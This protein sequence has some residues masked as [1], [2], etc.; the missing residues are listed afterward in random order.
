LTALPPDDPFG[1]RAHLEEQRKKRRQQ[2]RDS[3]LGGA[4]EWRPEGP[5]PGPPPGDDDAGDGSGDPGDK[6]RVYRLLK[7]P[8][9]NGAGRVEYTVVDLPDDCPV[10]PLGKQDKVFWFLDPHG[11]LIPLTSSEFGQKTLQGLFAGEKSSHWLNCA[12]PQINKNERWVGFAAQYA[13]QALMDAC[14][15]KGPFEVRD[16]VRGLG[17]WRGEDGELIQ[18]LGNKIIV[19][20]EE[21]RPGEIG[22]YVYPGRPAVP[23]PLAEGGQEAAIAVYD[24]F[25]SWNWA[26]PD[27]DPRLL[28]GWL[29]CMILGAALD[30]RPMVFFTGDAGTGKSTLQERLKKMTPGRMESTVDATPAALRQIINQDAKGISFDEIEADMLN[31]QAQLVMK[32][33]RVA[34]SGGTVFRGGKDHQS[35]EFQLRGCFAFS[36]IMPPSMRAQ[37]MQRLTFLRLFS[38]KPGQKLRKLTDKHLKE[39]GRKLVGRIVAGWERWNETLE[40]YEAGL[41]RI[42]HNQ[43]GARQFGSLLAAADLLMH[44]SVPEPEVVDGLVRGLERESLYEYENAE[45]TWLKTF[46]RIMQAQPEVWRSS[47]FPT[48]GEVVREFLNAPRDCADGDTIRGK[49]QDQLN[50]VGLAIVRTRKDQR[51]WLAVPPTH[52]Q[53]TAMFANTDLRAHGGEGVWT[54]V[55]RGADKWDPATQTGVWFAEKVAH[56]ER[57]KCTLIRLDATVE[58]QGV[59]TPIFD[60]SLDDK[61]EIDPA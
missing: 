24:D 40:A 17:C 8:R 10:I 31:D 21:H 55:L 57:Q 2:G 44:D 45:P 33:A 5:P 38:L 22:G 26:R 13:T 9:I 20:G 61:T 39:T 28:L 58:L 29:G 51:Y 32:L 27:L 47:G 3:I 19:D 36:A 34:A 15:K 53:L 54:G 4:A 18:H 42:G 59:K 1:D 43:R 6:P 25:R 60:R 7:I 46:R 30:W 37:D 16:K 12:F 11:Q 52:P 56:L 48:V 14:A 50:R 49:R 41:V 23:A 35:A